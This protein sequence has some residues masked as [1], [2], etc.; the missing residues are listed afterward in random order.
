MT[1]AKLDSE[2]AMKSKIAIIPARGNSKRLPRKNILPLGGMPMLSYPVR[3]AIGSGIFDQV[4]VSTEDAEIA[5]IA[6]KCGAMVHY[7]SKELAQDRSTMAQVC[8]SVLSEY[9]CHEFC[10]LYATAVLIT[11]D[12]IIQAY[13]DLHQHPKADYVMGVS[14]YNLPPVQALKYDEDGFLSYMWPEFRGVQSQ[15]HPDLCVSNGSF[16]WA[17]TKVFMREKTFY[18]TKLKG[19]L[20]SNEEMIDID[21]HDDYLL[22]RS[23]MRR[24]E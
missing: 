20:V 7:R 10:C 14:K 1:L 2:L 5:S 13:N 6:E 24:L 23:K 3:A 9:S 16:V 18:G 11:S 21:T 15:F 4:I 12:T 8:L 17:D 22:A 19:Y